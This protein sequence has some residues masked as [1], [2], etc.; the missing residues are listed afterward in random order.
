M[1]SRIGEI[2]Y[3]RVLYGSD[4]APVS[5]DQV[6]FS[7]YN[8]GDNFSQSDYTSNHVDGEEFLT[9]TVDGKT[10]LSLAWTPVIPGSITLAINENE[11]SDDG[12]GNIAYPGN[13]LTVDYSKGVL[14]FANA[15]N[16][17]EVSVTYDYNN[18]DVP[19]HA[20]DI[21]IRIVTAPIQAK[22]RKLRTLYSFDK[23]H[24]VA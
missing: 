9:N 1:L 20:P 5:K 17:L 11:Y 24:T 8:L 23:L 6:M 3:L 16:G 10:S 18:M 2:R 7:N 21:K 15:V 4:K 22:S 19:V 13:A 14:T 12:N